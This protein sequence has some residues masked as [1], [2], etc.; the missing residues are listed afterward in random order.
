M[1]LV[2]LGQKRKMR[3]GLVWLPGK[4]FQQYA[5]AFAHATNGVG[6]EKVGAVLHLAQ[7]TVFR[8]REEQRQIELGRSRPQLSVTKHVC[9]TR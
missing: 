4:R 5:K 3:D 7:K 8:D 1:L 2:C 6:I 9:D